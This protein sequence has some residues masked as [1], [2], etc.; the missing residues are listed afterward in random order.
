VTAKEYID[1]GA[2]EA[3]VK[4][5]ADEASQIIQREMEALFPEVLQERQRLEA[6]LPKEPP[7]SAAS[8][9]KVTLAPVPKPVKWL[10]TALAALV[11]LLM[12][13]ILLNFYYFSLFGGQRRQYN[14]LLVQQNNLLVREARVKEDM[15]KIMSPG[16]KQ[17]ALTPPAN[18]GNAYCTLYWNPRSQ[19]VLLYIHQLPKPEAGKQYQLWAFR[20]NQA[21]DAGTL[22]PASGDFLQRMKNSADAQAFAITLE[23]AG[24]SASPTR[25]AI[26]VMGNL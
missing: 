2:I 3:C 23:N 5:E 6:T 20:G 18:S 17:V 21:V 8:N 26:V 7:V 19:E 1:S 16:M 24:G 10:R 15:Q 11:V 22:D 9:A 4:G 14:A 12:G 13:S 25:E